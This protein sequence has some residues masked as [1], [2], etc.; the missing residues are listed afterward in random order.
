M[1]DADYSQNHGQVTGAMKR[2]KREGLHREEPKSVGAKQWLHLSEF[3][4]RPL[5]ERERFGELVFPTSTGNLW[6]PNS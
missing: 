4:M 1:E 5:R 2:M 6:E 3:A